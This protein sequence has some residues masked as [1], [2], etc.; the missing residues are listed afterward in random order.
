M[1]MLLWFDSDL[2]IKMHQVKVE[3]ISNYQPYTYR[4]AG[5]KNQSVCIIYKS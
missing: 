3:K 2:R 5:I 1:A 4:T